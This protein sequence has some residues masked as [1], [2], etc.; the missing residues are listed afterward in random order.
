P[1]RASTNNGQDCDCAVE[2]IPGNTDIIAVRTPINGGLG[3]SFD[4]G[5]IP[6]R[7]HEHRPLVGYD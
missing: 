3:V 5:D 1:Q 2:M 7:I 4:K 6:S